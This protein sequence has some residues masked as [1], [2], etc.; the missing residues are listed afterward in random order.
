MKILQKIFTVK[1][2]ILL[3]I[4]VLA[5][6]VRFYKLDQLPA[7]NADE[8]SNGYDAYSLILTGKDQHGNPWPI[9]FQSFNDYKPGL[10][11]Y[12][13]LPFIKLLGLTIWAVRIPGALAGVLSVYVIYLL[14]KELF[15]KERLALAASFFLAISPWH[16]HFSRGGW[17]VNVA[18]LL[19][20]LGVWL[21]IKSMNAGV[22]LKPLLFSVA[23]FA[24]S[25]YTYH[26]ERVVVPLL[27]IALFVIYWKEV[28]KHFKVILVAAAVG[29]VLVLPLARDITTGAVASR[30]AGV[31]L[32]ADSG[33]RSRIE[34]QRGEHG[35]VNSFLGR[36][37]HNKA[38]N[39]GLAFVS[40]WFVHYWGEFLFL[41]G[42]VI[43]RNKVPETGQMYLTDIVFVA[44]GLYTMI[45]SFD[46]K[47]GV[48]FAW[49]LF[50]PVAAALT[51]QAP[52]ALR[53]HNMV[54]PIVIV[55]AF[56]FDA[57]ISWLTAKKKK[58]K[59]AGFTIL[60]ILIVW[61]FARY[62]H[63]YWVHMA[64]EY[65]YSSQYGVAELVSYVKGN[66]DKYQK[67][68]VT[69]RYDQP[70]ILFLFYMKYDPA[71]FQAEH[72]L[73]AKD[74][75]GFSTVNHFDKYYFATIKFQQAKEE[76]PN[77]LIAGT[78]EEIV[79]EAN[80]IKDIY[81]TNGFLYFRVVAN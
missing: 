41:S 48:I 9:H 34:E 60:G 32:F 47:K 42:D 24:T 78:S 38:V 56:G 73:T 23:A 19:M 10:Y 74:Q 36:A 69:D 55:S 64:K 49:L 51:F 17:E 37:L 43:Q 28:K 35:N 40:N 62:E 76:N 33:P 2:L 45:K 79:K 1:N 4:I 22:R 65:P 6:V 31:G 63:M 5:V 81:G 52:H 13:D 20:M 25:L 71:K 14:V 26:A 18:T 68:L 8:A 53:A 46:R 15:G 77:T 59:I 3:G 67:I 66:E 16:I 61:G 39:Y 70:Y 54:I 30:A 11:V 44:V 80:I 75:Y 7:L 57:I 58:L 12:L 21:F 27:G 72:N 50:A 29:L